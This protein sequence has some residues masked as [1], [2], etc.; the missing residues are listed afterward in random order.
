M[1]KKPK[2]DFIPG[3]R[4][5]RWMDPRELKANARNWRTHPQRQRQAFQATLAA[6]GWAGAALLNETT[7]NLLD[8][9]MRV[10]EAIKANEKSIPVLVGRWTEAQEKQVLATLDPLGAMAGTNASALSSLTEEVA[11]SSKTLEGLTSANVKAFKEFTRDLSSYAALVE[12]GDAPSILLER[13]KRAKTKAERTTPEVDT[14]DVETTTDNLGSIRDNSFKDD[15][16]FDSSNLW[17]IPDL[18]DDM[19]STVVPTSTWSK[20]SESISSTAWYCYSAGPASFPAPTQREGGILGFFTEDFRFEMAW[21]DTPSFTQRLVEQ[22]WGG[23]CLPDYST[24]SNWPFPIRLHNLYRSRWCGRYWQE[25]GVPVIP[26]IQSIGDTPLTSEEDD[27]SF[28]HLI[29]ETLPDTIPVAAI[30]V[31]TSEKKSTDYWA[32]VGAM[33]REAIT[34]RHIEN[35]VIYGGKEFVKYISGHLPKSKKTTFTMIESY[36]AK[37]R[38]TK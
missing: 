34:V 20:S 3:I 17:G 6:N 13:N 8:G 27:I 38:K 23:V 30:Q 24:W 19:L 36:V 21:N 18:R 29:L 22:D 2:L 11:R 5:L 15:V 33:I 9:H 10:A 7:G 12:T 1:A 31:R 14:E 35:L 16:I 26:I 28:T 32:G 4:E 37:R 25:A